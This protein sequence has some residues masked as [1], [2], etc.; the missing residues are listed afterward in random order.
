MRR[1][2]FD[3]RQDAQL[4]HDNLGCEFPSIED[5]YLEAFNAAR[6]IWVELLRQRRDPRHCSFEVHDG[7]GSLLFVLP[8]WEVLESCRNY[9]RGKS[10]LLETFRE[11]MDTV[12]HISRVH[13]E[14]VQQMESARQTLRESAKLIAATEMIAIS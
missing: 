6:E 9:P 4:T 7:A 8:F 13:D 14:F 10:T 2:Y 12:R 3:F 5:A 1:Y 11:S